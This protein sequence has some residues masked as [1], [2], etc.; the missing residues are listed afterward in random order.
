MAGDNVVASK[1]RDAESAIAPSK[2]KLTAVDLEPD[3]QQQERRTVQA[4]HH[5]ET[6]PASNAND[7]TAT[8]QALHNT[9]SHFY[10]RPTSK[11]PDGRRHHA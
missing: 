7:T 8:R 10:T 3:G 1:A 6:E 5:K 11:T 9:S 2:W 4:R